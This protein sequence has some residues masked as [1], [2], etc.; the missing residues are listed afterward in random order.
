MPHVSNYSGPV[1]VLGGGDA[2][3]EGSCGPCEG[4]G[5][6]TFVHGAVRTTLHKVIP[7]PF[8]FADR[9][10][11]LALLSPSPPGSLRIY[12]TSDGGRSWR[13]VSTLS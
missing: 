9:S 3:L 4:Y 5:T 6:V 8:A 10:H 1:A 7:G 13:R 12:S 11:G 2:V